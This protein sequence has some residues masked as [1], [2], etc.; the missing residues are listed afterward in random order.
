M[1]LETGAKVWRWGTLSSFSS[2]SFRSTGSYTQQG[3]VSCQI[4]STRQPGRGR[5]ASDVW[6]S[7]RAYISVNQL[8][9]L[10]QCKP[11]PGPTAAHSHL[12]LTLNDGSVGSINTVF[13][14]LQLGLALVLE[15][16]SA[17]NIRHAAHIAVARGGVRG[18]RGSRVCGL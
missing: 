13:D 15:R 8:Q 10:Q 18:M 11:A 5:Y 3:L 4:S 6:T 17:Y 14:S 12:I 2:R 1:G 9:G 16:C 7:S